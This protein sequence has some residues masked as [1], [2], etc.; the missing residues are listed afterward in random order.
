MTDI[1]RRLA[2]PF[3]PA[4]IS[5]RVGSTT[6]AKDKGMALAYIDSRDVQDRLDTVCGAGGWQ[7]RYPHAGQKTVCEIGIKVDQEWIWKA[8]GAGDTDVE[9]EKGALSDAF[10]RAAV[11]WGIGRYLYDMDSPWVQIV[12]K[13]RSY[14]IADHEMP[15]LQKLLPGSKAATAKAVE[16]GPGVTKARTWVNEHIRELHA[17]E[18]AEPVLDTMRAARA[19]WIRVKREFPTLWAGPDGSGLRGEGLKLATVH[20][21]RPD[22]DV[23]VKEVERMAVE[24]TT[25]AT[26]E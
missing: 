10:K 24:T 25:K 13:G 26:A 19:N 12:P 20:N 17:C 21:C 5:W 2:D 7:C 4:R 8:D 23:F 1:L 14:V 11:K 9:Q 16:N 22:F 18:N 3:D 15:K 6:Q